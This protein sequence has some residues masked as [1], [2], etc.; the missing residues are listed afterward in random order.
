MTSYENDARRSTQDRRVRAPDESDAEFQVLSTDAG[1]ALL[2]EV[3]AVKTPGPADLTRWRK[4]SAPE[5]VAAAIRLAEARRKAPAKFS[6]GERM[7]LDP[8][9]LEQATAEAVAVH[10]ARRFEAD[11]VVD[12]CSGIGGDAIALAGRSQVL[13]VDRDQGMGRRVA[14][15]AD[16]YDRGGRVLPC[17]ATAEAFPIPG[18]AWAHIDPDRR[19]SGR[20]RAVDAE[21]YVPGPAFL[22]ALMRRAP[23][24]AIKLG[25]ASDFA[26]FAEDEACEVEIVSLGGEAKEAV[27]WFGA[28]VS[29]RRR[30]T[31]LPE[32]VTWTDR[33]GDEPWSEYPVVA[34]TSRW[35]YDPDPA[36]SRA[37]LV[38]SFA[39][40]HGLGRI[41]AD[42][43]YLTSDAPLATPWLE[44]FE[45]LGVHPLDLK[46]LRRLIDVDRLGPVSVKHRTTDLKPE[47]LRPLL[48][49]HGDSPTVLF[50]TGGAGP[51]RAIVTRKATLSTAG[52]PDDTAG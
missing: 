32:G 5:V 34:P 49:H 14:W 40:D 48:R 13:A 26:R 39:R 23:G 30:A 31:K 45:I 12:F 3:Q 27:V 35:L 15:N 7:W 2:V 51:G 29:C 42:L 16:V 38:D 43:P 8:V 6:R 44:A 4:G 20:G 24:G 11:V 22:H 25:P 37:G 28:A 52:L 9:G 17:R 50:L 33:M 1:R 36:L 21:G 46:K 47:A 18:G 19:T 41:A 10:K